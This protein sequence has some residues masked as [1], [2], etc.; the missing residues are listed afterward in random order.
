MRKKNQS[1]QIHIC[2]VVSKRREEYRK[3][4]KKN[5]MVGIYYELFDIYIY[6]VDMNKK[7]KISLICGSVK[8][9]SKSL[10]QQC[11]NRIFEGKKK[12]IVCEEKIKRIYCF[13]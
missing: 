9:K 5:C 1:K 4:E 12:V 11:V 7:S 8:L 3:I 2:K 13:I 6:I 10:K